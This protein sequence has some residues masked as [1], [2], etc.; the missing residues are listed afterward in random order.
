MPIN[1]NCTLIAVVGGKGGVGKSVAAA[2]LACAFL[3]ELRTQVLLI[4]SDSKSVGDQ[5]I[6]LGLKPQKTLRELTTL[7]QSLNSLSPN[8][9]VTPHSSGL[10][11]IGAVR[12]PEE[13]LDVNPELMSKLLEFLSRQYKIILV[14]I[15]NDITPLQH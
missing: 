7:S 12:G 11:Y 6:I 3:T 15:G 13:R 5:N 8:Q 2:N 4:D 9:I 10:H 1:P 14:D